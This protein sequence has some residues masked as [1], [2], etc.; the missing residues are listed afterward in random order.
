MDSPVAAATAA[1]SGG[2]GVKDLMRALGNDLHRAGGGVARGLQKAL[3]ETQRGL[4]KVA[5]ASGGGG[6]GSLG[7][8]TTKQ[9]AAARPECVGTM[10]CPVY[11]HYVLPVP[12]LLVEVCQG[13]VPA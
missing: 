3:D 12:V 8:S 4:Q 11:C 9:A 6:G 13:P 2:G 5:Q 10:K 1:T 7:A